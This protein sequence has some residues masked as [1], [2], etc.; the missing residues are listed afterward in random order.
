MI[1]LLGNSFE[2]N[3]KSDSLLGLI[4]DHKLLIWHLYDNLYIV[5]DVTKTVIMFIPVRDVT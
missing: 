1:F 3:R 2:D 5:S 4:V